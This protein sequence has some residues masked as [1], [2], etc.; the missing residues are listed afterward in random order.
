M[1]RQ[2]A[3]GAAPS[4]SVLEG[5]YN[6]TYLIRTVD[7]GGSEAKGGSDDDDDDDD[8]QERRVLFRCGNW[9]YTGNVTLDKA[10]VLL[11]DLPRIIPNAPLDYATIAGGTADRARGAHR[12][13]H[14]RRRRRHLP[15]RA[16]KESVAMPSFP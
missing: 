6:Q 15:R 16:A 1:D 12:A 7:K 5:T 8:Y 14:L 13:S 10:K 2:P 3:T 4:A 9:C 11:S